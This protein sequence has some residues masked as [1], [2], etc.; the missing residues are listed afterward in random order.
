[1]SKYDKENR[2]LSYLGEILDFNRKVN[3]VSRETTSSDLQK[4]AADCLIPFE[5]TGPPS[6][7]IF[8]IGSGAGFPGIILL[9]AFP[10]LEAAL[11]ER[12]SKKARFLENIVRNYILKAEVINA[13][14]VEKAG[15]FPHSSFDSGFMKYVKMEPRIL[16]S[17]GH[18]LKDNGQFVHYSSL[19]KHIFSKTESFQLVEYQYR[20]DLEE[21]LRTISVFSKNS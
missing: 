14:F 1:M 9:L 5:F 12:T 10:S 21:P 6:G 7:R 4:I 19:A 2:L 17:V 16:K 18:L 3:I 15:S 20:L 11:F 8:D 13:D